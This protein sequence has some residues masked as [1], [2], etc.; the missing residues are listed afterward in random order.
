MRSFDWN[1]LRYFLAV[2]RTG[3]LTAA[4][5]RMG[6]DHATVSRHIRTLEETLGADLFN[7]SPRG[8]SLTDAGER[9]LFQT[10]T[11]E[12]AAAA[13]HND[14]AGE[15]YA[16]SGAVRIGAP[17]GFGAFFLAPHLGELSR[18]HPQ[19]E[20]QIVAMPRIFS[21][22]KRE[23][24]IAIG[25]E[26]PDKGR[27]FSRKLVDYT[28]HVYAARSYLAEAPTIAR[29]EDLSSHPLIGY[30]PELVFTPKLDYVKDV[31]ESLVPRLSSSNLFAQLAATRSGAGLCILPD[32]MARSSPDLVRVLPEAIEIVRTFWIMAHVD[33]RESARIQTVMSFISDLVKANRDIFWSKGSGE[34]CEPFSDPR[35]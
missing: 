15:K 4:A 17:D 8:Y 33:A 34:A 18:R 16:L 7:R 3:R 32:F 23:A 24:D 22:S 28:L 9:L 14:I 31:G 26:R 6:T 20:L 27:L 29:R 11:M 1:D 2:A 35:S 19:L 13:I 5:Q 12:S 30:I 21:L 10:E 25:L